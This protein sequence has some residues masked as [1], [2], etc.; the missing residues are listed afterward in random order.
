MGSLNTLTA[1]C[2]LNVSLNDPQENKHVY[3]TTVPFGQ[4]FDHL[5]EEILPEHGHMLLLLYIFD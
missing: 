4:P 5:E 2:M 1:A 3:V